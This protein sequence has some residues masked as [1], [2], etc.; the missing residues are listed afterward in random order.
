MFFDGESPTLKT[1]NNYTII[2]TNKV[3]KLEYYESGVF[4]LIQQVA[5][6]NLMLFSNILKI[7]KISF[8][9]F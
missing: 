9:T 4:E 1:F 3:T 2:M 5:L 8:G 6:V 7:L